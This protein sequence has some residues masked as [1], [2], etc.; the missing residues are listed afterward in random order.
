LKKNYPE[1][2]KNP[3]TQNQNMT[4]NVGEVKRI[5]NDVKEEMIFQYP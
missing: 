3:N 2:K 4:F 5:I 1:E